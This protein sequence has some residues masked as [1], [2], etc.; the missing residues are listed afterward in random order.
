[1]LLADE[2][3][4]LFD[5]VV[6]HEPAA[7]PFGDEQYYCR[8]VHG[9]ANGATRPVPPCFED[10]TGTVSTPTGLQSV[11]SFTNGRFKRFTLGVRQVAM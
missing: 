6:V 7:K 3:G 2:G 1:M 11:R 4:V 10:R 5:N 9:V 8:N